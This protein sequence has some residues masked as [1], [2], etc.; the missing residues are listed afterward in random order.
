MHSPFVLLQDYTKD[1]NAFRNGL[2]HK[3]DAPVEEPSEII[4]QELQATN[5]KFK[6]ILADC[7]T[8]MAK[9]TDTASKNKRYNDLK[10]QLS[11]WLPDMESRVEKCSADIAPG[12]DPSRQLDEIKAVTGDVIAQGKLVDDLCN[13]GSDLVQILEELDCKDTPKAR[14]IQGTVENVQTRY[15]QIQEEVVD[16]QHRLNDALVQSKD[17]VHNLDSL[18]KWTTETENLFNNMT[19]VSLDREALNEQIQAHRVLTSDIEN[20]KGQVDAIVDQCQGQGEDDKVNNLLD[21][22]DSLISHAQDRGNELEDVV[23]KLGTLHGNVNQLES[24]LTNAVHSLK[25]ESADFDH[26]S[27]KNKIENLYR[28]KQS[29]QADLDNIKKIGRALI[30]DPNT[31]DKNRLR[32]TLADT[33]AK[34]HDLTELLVQM[35]SFAVSLSCTIQNNKSLL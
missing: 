25:R 18:L 16:K 14:E 3:V 27:L 11:K 2:Q 12:A 33:Q 24:W 29:K 17:A 23:Q 9:L 7:T 35:I 1:A 4:E 19:P 34:W 10:R 15:D 20:H 5:D 8:L 28:Q 30:N 22:F 6:G 26:D 32:E 21:R 31:G 13:V